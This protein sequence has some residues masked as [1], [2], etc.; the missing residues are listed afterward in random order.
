MGYVGNLPYFSDVHKYVFCLPWIN[1]YIPKIRRTVNVGHRVWTPPAVV[2]FFSLVGGG[3]I[4]VEKEL[5]DNNL[6]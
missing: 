3:Q 6:S 2:M 4:V 5:D 1:Q